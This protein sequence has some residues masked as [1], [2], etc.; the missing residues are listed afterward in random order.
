MAETLK[1][2]LDPQSEKRNVIKFST[3]NKIEAV[4]KQR[5]NDIC[6][7]LSDTWSGIWVTFGCSSDFSG[8]VYMDSVLGLTHK[9]IP[10]PTTT[11]LDCKLL[12]H[13]ASTDF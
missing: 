8:K 3:Q 9:S 1:P 4:L 12:T 10:G 7:K 5:K 13:R 11:Q 6:G 2:L